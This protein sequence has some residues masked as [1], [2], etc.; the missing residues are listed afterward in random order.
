MR[1]MVDRYGNIHRLNNQNQHHSF[2]GKPAYI[3]YDGTLTWYDKGR[4]IK[5]LHPDGTITPSNR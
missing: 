2:D 5:R 1:L 4:F 3:G